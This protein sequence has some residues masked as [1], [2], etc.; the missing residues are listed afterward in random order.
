M[1][2][3]SSHLLYQHLQLQHVWVAAP[4]LLHVTYLT[5]MTYLVI[6]TTPVHCI[7]SQHA[8]SQIAC[9]PAH[10]TVVAAY[11]A[12]VFAGAGSSCLSSRH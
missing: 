4:G 2:R 12:A 8:H 9:T 7:P 11:E 6:H 1:H 3:K 10:Q 5:R